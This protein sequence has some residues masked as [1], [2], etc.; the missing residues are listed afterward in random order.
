[1]AYKCDYGDLLCKFAGFSV[2]NP[3]GVA[4]SA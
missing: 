3:A 2:G 1:M 4:E